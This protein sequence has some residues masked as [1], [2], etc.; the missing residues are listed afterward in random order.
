MIDLAGKVRQFDIA[1]NLIDS[2]KS[3]NIE[4]QIDTFS[5]LIRRYV[6]AGLASEAVHAFNRM[7]DYGCEPDRIAFSVVI[8]I[9]FNGWCRAGD[10]AEAEKVFGEM[11]NLGIKPNVYTYTIVIDALCR[12]GQI[13]RA[14]DVFRR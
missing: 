6:R 11:K 5:I 8:S 9:L 2:M 1:W 12:C 7:E 14:H 10:I 4:I 3:R 13:W